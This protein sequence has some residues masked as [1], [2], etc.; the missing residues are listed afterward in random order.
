MVKGAALRR[1]LA[2]L[3][4][5]RQPVD[6]DALQPMLAET[7]GAPFSAAGWIFELKHDGFR[8]L[9]ERRDGAV[10]LKYRSGAAATTA[11][12]EIERALSALPGGDFVI[13]GEVVV[14]GA[15]GRPSF[16][17]LQKRFQLRRAQDVASAARRLPA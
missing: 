6:L 12:P 5:P 4:A 15:G 17:A 14:F 2:R 13:D 3:G 10:R 1:E 16:Q 7:A 11:F 8:L 9:A